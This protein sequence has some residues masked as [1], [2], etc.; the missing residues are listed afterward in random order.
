MTLA[1]SVHSIHVVA[2]YRS[3]VV[4]VLRKLVADGL[5]NFHVGLA[6]KVVGGCEPAEVGHGL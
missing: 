6:D 1:R 4:D 5:A 2:L 3:T